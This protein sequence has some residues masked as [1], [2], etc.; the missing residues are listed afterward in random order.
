MPDGHVC[1]HLGW[2]Y[3]QCRSAA[4]C[5]S[6]T[7]SRKS[8][9]VKQKTSR[10]DPGDSSS[11]SIFDDKTCITSAAKPAGGVLRQGRARPAG[12]VLNFDNRGVVKAI[13]H[14]DLADGRSI[15][16]APGAT[17]APGRERPSSN[18]SWAMS[19]GS[20]AA[21]AV[22]AAAVAAKGGRAEPE[23]QTLTAGAAAGDRPRSRRF[24]SSRL[25][26]QQQQSHDSDL[27]RVDRRA[28]SCRDQQRYRRS[29]PLCA[30]D[31][32]HRDGLQCISWRCPC[33]LKSSRSRRT[34]RSRSY[35]AASHPER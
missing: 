27:D 31:P 25:D 29:P 7:D 23:R 35:P 19:A 18:R 30:S 22:P 5:P 1:G 28:V 12:L 4:I 15:E 3:R 9:P 2:L 32:C 13:D 21:V 8:N 33:H 6:L 14:K 34:I 11:T 17:P 10:Q 16:P 26:R 24:V 20:A